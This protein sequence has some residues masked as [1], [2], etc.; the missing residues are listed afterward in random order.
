[1]YRVPKDNPKH[2]Y[3][4][5]HAVTTLNTEWVENNFQKDWIKCIKMKARNP[6]GHNPRPLR[7]FHV[8]PGKPRDDDGDEAPFNIRLQ[9]KGEHAKLTPFVQ[10]Q[11]ATCLLDGFASGLYLFGLRDEANNLVKCGEKLHQ[12]NADLKSCFVGE[13][14]RLVN[15][16]NLVL[17]LI[18]K[19]KTASEITIENLLRL[20]DSFPI[21]V[22]LM[23]NKGMQGQHAITIFNN[24]IL[25]ASS[26]H[27]LLKSQ[28]ALN[29]CIWCKNEKRICTGVWQAFQL[30][31]KQQFLDQKSFVLKCGNQGWIECLKKNTRYD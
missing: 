25:D 5:V 20:D 23:D 9:K 14:N 4:Y 13:C 22:L 7:F 17:R 16:H 12:A 1:M 26:K 24:Q 3:D 2:N 8:P 18:S 30:Q 11:D 28:E 19:H 31:K 21:L 27:R 6:Q 15:K 29:W 10:E